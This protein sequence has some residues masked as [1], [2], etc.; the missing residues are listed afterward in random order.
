M[1]T[2]RSNVIS[3]TDNNI[4]NEARV[5]NMMGIMNTLI[6]EQKGIQEEFLSNSKSLMEDVKNYYNGEFSVETVVELVNY[7]KNFLKDNAEINN[8]SSSAIQ[9]IFASSN[10]IKPAAAKS[11]MPGNNR[12]IVRNKKKGKTRK[13]KNSKR[14]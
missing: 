7:I 10:R 3:Q 13:L 5:I 12:N 11:L 14:D 6:E 9:N 4:R 2:R 1:A 8:S